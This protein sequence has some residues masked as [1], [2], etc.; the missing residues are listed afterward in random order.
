LLVKMAA[1]SFALFLGKLSFNKMVSKVACIFFA[2][3]CV[4]VGIIEIY[5]FNFE[6][7]CKLLAF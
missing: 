6:K 3:T 2:E 7:R 5:V 4:Y 1:H